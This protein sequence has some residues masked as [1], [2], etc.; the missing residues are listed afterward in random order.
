MLRIKVA[1]GKEMLRGHCKRAV[2]SGRHW[3]FSMHLT[4]Q[5]CAHAHCHTLILQSSA[6]RAPAAVSEKVKELSAGRARLRL[7][8]QAARQLGTALGSCRVTE[9]SEAGCIELCT[10]VR[11]ALLF[12]SRLFPGRSC[13]CGL[14]SCIGCGALVCARRPK[15]Y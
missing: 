12:Y 3:I 10:D 5:A 2:A 6:A 14:S 7:E 1:P 11:E 13:C 8:H 15:C 9:F 4:H